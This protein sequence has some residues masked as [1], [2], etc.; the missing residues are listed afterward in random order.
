MSDDEHETPDVVG[1]FRV[2]ESEITL[3]EVSGKESPEDEPLSH[4]VC[5]SEAA[6]TVLISY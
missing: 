1:H 6:K 4:R 5:D 2:M 3:R